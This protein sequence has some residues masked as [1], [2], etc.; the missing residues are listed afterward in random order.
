MTE[1]AID[2]SGST[3]RR[4][5]DMNVGS[6]GDLAAVFD[7]HVVAEFVSKDLD[8]TL[9]TMT[10]EPVVVHVPVIT[11]G[12]GR[13]QVASFYREHFL[14]AWPEDV[15]VT[16]ISRTVGSNRVIDELLVRF[17]HTRVMD[18]WLPGV[19]PTGRRVALPIVV[20]V[21]FDGDKIAYEHI[22][23]DQ[24]SLLVQVGMVEPDSLPVTGG[25]EAAWLAGDGVA[26]NGLIDAIT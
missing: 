1:P 17:T 14:P 26:M 22:Y 16:Q 12:R 8:A 13:H 23:W 7:A 15:E 4:G 9:A 19:A 10:D 11:G 2:L 6:R 20:V 5:D 24:A 3:R 25:E 18:F 21:G